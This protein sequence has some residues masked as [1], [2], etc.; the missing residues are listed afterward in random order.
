MRTCKC[1]KAIFC[2]VAANSP[3]A[4]AKLWWVTRY[5]IAQKRRSPIPINAS[6]FNQLSKHFSQPL[7]ERVKGPR[8][9]SLSRSHPPQS[10]PKYPFATLHSTRVFS[11]FRRHASSLKQVYMFV[12]SM[13]VLVVL[14][15]Y[16]AEASSTSKPPAHCTPRV[17][18]V[19]QV[20]LALPTGLE[21]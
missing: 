18:H 6:Q 4:L 1:E 3:R 10:G 20:L 19:M 16:H 21:L 15:G 8:P 9:C 12:D 7:P 13:M 11:M 17:G 14:S 2:T 5:S